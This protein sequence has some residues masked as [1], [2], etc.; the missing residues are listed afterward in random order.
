MRSSARELPKVIMLPPVQL[1]HSNHTRTWAGL[2]DTDLAEQLCGL[3]TDDSHRNQKGLAFPE[4]R[5]PEPAGYK[6]KH[7]MALSTA[8]AGPRENQSPAA[9]W[10]VHLQPWGP[11]KLCAA[12]GHHCRCQEHTC[13][14][15]LVAGSG[16]TP[17]P[18]RPAS[19]YGHVEA[20]VTRLSILREKAVT[21]ASA[22][23]LCWV[24]GIPHCISFQWF[25]IK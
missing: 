4:M 7:P 20:L 8:L 25:P 9:C 24:Y 3:L 17:K 22:K 5:L 15:L 13:T 6:Q 23:V 11:F 18:A 2:F 10:K 12:L 14:P 21:Q 1:P 19:G 16:S